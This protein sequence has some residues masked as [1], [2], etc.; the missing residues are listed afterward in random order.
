MWTHCTLPKVHW[1]RHFF[2][3]QTYKHRPEHLKLPFVLGSSQSRS[4]QNHADTGR[5]KGAMCEFKAVVP[6][7]G[8]APPRRSAVWIRKKKV[9]LEGLPHKRKAEVEATPNMLPNQLPRQRLENM[10]KHILP[11]ASPAQQPSCQG[12]DPR[13]NSFPLRQ[14]H[15]LGSPNHD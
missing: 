9:F 12:R 8:G 5:V 1:W 10:M 7:V 15:M 2:D 11:L 13:Q 4:K 14:E 3:R 6:K